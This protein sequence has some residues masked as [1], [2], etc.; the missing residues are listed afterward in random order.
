VFYNESENF[1]AA[2][3]RRNFYAN[4]LPS[5]KGNTEEYGFNLSL[6]NNKLVLRGNRFESFD[7]NVGFQGTVANGSPR[8]MVGVI[9][10]WVEEANTNPHLVASR[11][12]DIQ[13][14]L[15]FLPS[16][17]TELYQ[18]QVSG[19][20]P[21]INGTF[22]NQ[23]AGGANDT[24]DRIAKGVEFEVV[25]NPTPNWRILANVA[26]Q[27]TVRTNMLPFMKEYAAHIEPLVAEL[28]NRPVGPYPTGFQL[29]QPLPAN[30]ETLAQQV[31]RL[32]TVPMA[33]ELAAENLASP[34]Q[35]KWRFN[36]VTNYRFGKD[37]IFGEKLK[38]WSVGGG[39]RWQSKYAIGYPSHRLPNTVP[40]YDIA[41]PWYGPSDLNV[42]A[43]VSYSR[44][45]WGDRIDW[46]M[47]LNGTNLY[48]AR[49][50]I[51]VTA[52]PWGQVAIMRTAPEQRWFLT[53]TF[54]F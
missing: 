22:M 8:M 24:Y 12:A 31:D 3:I 39:V 36:L 42:D 7:R 49:D 51:P 54:S 47:Q 2:G 19:T 21:N 34:E 40:V 37:A 52:Q 43:F 13:K 50:L 25:Y 18:L 15:S 9:S 16:N 35:R 6:F 11:N 30:L 20:A 4:P 44:K 33:L 45:I 17:I 27:E 28:G 32:M 41:N 5:P 46:K 29:G 10:N 53:N 26:R 38:G 1:T 14:I 48:Q 23:L